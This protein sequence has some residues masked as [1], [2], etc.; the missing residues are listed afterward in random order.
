VD[1]YYNP[2]NFTPPL[3]QTRV[4]DASVNP[5]AW[6]P[7]FTQNPYKPLP[8]AGIIERRRFYYGVRAVLG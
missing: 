1:K 8:D 4:L 7:F 5:V 6:T 2:A 3:P